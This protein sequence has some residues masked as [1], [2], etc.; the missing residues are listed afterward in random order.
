M[1]NWKEGGSLDTFERAKVMVK[2]LLETYKR[3][4]MDSARENELHAYMLNL[5]KQAGLERLP[6]L[7]DFQ[8]A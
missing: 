1:R 8:P 5:A 2:K 7:E 3:P 6:I 4:E